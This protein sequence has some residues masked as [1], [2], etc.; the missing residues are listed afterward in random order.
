MVLGLHVLVGLFA[1]FVQFISSFISLW[2]KKLVGRI[3]IFLNLLRLYLW[4][5][6]WS[7]LENV[8]CALKKNVYPVAFI[9]LF[10]LDLYFN[11]VID[12]LII[13]SMLLSLHVFVSH[14][15][16]L[17][18]LFLVLYLCDLRSWLVQFQSFLIY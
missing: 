8:P 16:F 14:F 13:K 11:L 2:S 17:Y 9:C 3:S 6:M 1:F 7:I 10:L 18:N 4:P 12:P 5:S 15:V